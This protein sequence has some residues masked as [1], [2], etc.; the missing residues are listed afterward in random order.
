MHWP[1]PESLTAYL[2][3]HQRERYAQAVSTNERFVILTGGPG[4]GK[5]HST[6]EILKRFT[7]SGA[8]ATF[9]G[10][11]S[12]RLSEALHENQVTN[13]LKVSTIHSLLGVDFQAEGFDYTRPQFLYNQSNRLPLDLL[14]LDESGTIPTGLMANALLALP[15]SC[16]VL[17]VGDPDQLAPVGHGKPLMDMIAAGLPHA[18]LTELHRFAGRIAKICK[19]V[20]TGQTPEFSPHSAINWE[21]KE[22]P[23]NA[24]FMEAVSSSHVYPALKKISDRLREKGANPLTDIQ[25]IA[26]VN[27]KSPLSRANINKFMRDQFNSTGREIKEC[28][29][30]EG[31]KII[32]RKNHRFKLLDQDHTRYTANG[33]LGII[34]HVNPTSMHARFDGG[35]VR[36]PRDKWGDIQLGYCITGHS[37]IGSQWPFVVAIVDDYPGANLVCSRQ[38]WYTVFSRAQ[39]LLVVIGRN[40]TLQSHLRKIDSS[41]RRTLLA[42]KIR[43]RRDAATCAGSSTGAGSACATAT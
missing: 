43:E 28:K 14:I 40:A 39:K 15:D 21:A 27:E 30:R 12:Q 20:N 18:R 29:F 37:S 32:C 22:S 7:G 23:E 1:T 31:D 34:E 42:S 24:V 6:S 36:I 8:A 33:E 11:A 13:V 2:S 4:V 16:K 41:S 19:Q 9:M 25:F 5:T 38:Y 17:F 26:S 3:D 10:K 35:L